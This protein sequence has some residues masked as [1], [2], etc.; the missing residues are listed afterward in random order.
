MSFHTLF[1]STSAIDLTQYSKKK[2]RDHKRNALRSLFSSQKKKLAAED[3]SQLVMGAVSSPNLQRSLSVRSKA[4]T[5]IH[6]SESNGGFRS[7]SEE[8][9]LFNASLKTAPELTQ[10]LSKVDVCRYDT[11]EKW[12]AFMRRGKSIIVNSARSLVGAPPREHSWSHQDHLKKA[13]R[14][15][16][17]SSHEQS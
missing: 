16:L 2:N 12:A 10:A 8:T 17:Q 4:S 1:P 13:F 5:S 14:Q 9:S 11:K 15:E 3:Y 7:V 6:T